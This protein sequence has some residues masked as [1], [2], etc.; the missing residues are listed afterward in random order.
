MRGVGVT[1][2][3]I[4]VIELLAPQEVAKATRILPSDFPCIRRLEEARDSVEVKA[5]LAK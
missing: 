3:I 4:A 2:R 5:I 1:Q